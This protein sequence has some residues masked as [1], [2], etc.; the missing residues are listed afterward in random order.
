MSPPG[1]KR[2]APGGWRAT[3]GRIPVTGM[4][5]HYRRWRWVQSPFAEIFRAMN[6]HLSALV[7]ER[8][9]QK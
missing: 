3:Q 4:P 7:V 5:K 9:K 2:K 6:Q 1:T 8:R